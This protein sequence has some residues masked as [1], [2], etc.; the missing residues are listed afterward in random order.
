MAMVIL[1]IL[2]GKLIL[3]SLLGSFLYCI[4]LSGIIKYK[5]STAC[6]KN[7]ALFWSPAATQ[8]PHHQRWTEENGPGYNA[9]KLF[10]A[11]L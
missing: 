4:I 11:G 5:G 6:R 10:T 2:N 1:I 3:E 8:C 7:N 9:I